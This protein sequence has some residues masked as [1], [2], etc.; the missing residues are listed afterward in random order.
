MYVVCPFKRYLPPCS[1]GMGYDSTPTREGII[2]YLDLEAHDI[3]SIYYYIPT[4]M[5]IKKAGIAS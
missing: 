4:T 2:I 1:S 3:N 5:L